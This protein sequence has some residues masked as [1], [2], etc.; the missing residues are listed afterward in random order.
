MP[1]SIAE[2]VRRT[3][4]DVPNVPP[5]V[6]AAEIAV[7]L[8]LSRQRVSQIAVTDGFPAPVAVLSVGR[9]WLRE[10]IVDWARTQGRT[11]SEDS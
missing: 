3:L 8:G 1:T 9:I 2:R 7:M 6:A 11:M 5:L 10:D 4:S